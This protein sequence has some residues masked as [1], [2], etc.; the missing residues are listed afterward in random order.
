MIEIPS[1]RL[2]RDILGAVIEEYILREGTD[3][4]VQEAS[5]ESKIK[6]VHRQIIQGDVLI[7]F[8]PVTENCTLLTRNQFN[9]YSKDLQTNE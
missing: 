2:S 3:Y 1:E 6:Q 8:D 7:T 9:R 5:L 4:G